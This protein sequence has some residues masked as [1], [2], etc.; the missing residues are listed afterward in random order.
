MTSGVVQQELIVNRPSL[1]S[2]AKEVALKCPMVML[3][4]KANGSRATALNLS[5]TG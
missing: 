2:E 4:L 1:K 5:F 3:G